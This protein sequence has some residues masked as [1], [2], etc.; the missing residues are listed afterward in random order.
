MSLQGGD[1]SRAASLPAP[2]LFGVPEPTFQPNMNPD[3][4]PRSP[5]RGIVTALV[6]SVPLWALII[7]AV[8]LVL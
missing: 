8:R 4:D 5:A 7:V 1:V 6:I 3:D 2:A